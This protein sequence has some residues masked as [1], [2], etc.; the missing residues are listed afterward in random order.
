MDRFATPAACRR[1]LAR[2][3]GALALLT[4]ALAGPVAA[5]APAAGGGA[6]APAPAA[7]PAASP[8]AGAVA[9]G[10]PTIQQLEAMASTLENP[11]ARTK[12]VEQLRAL[13][14]A[15]K[16]LTPAKPPEPEASLPQTLGASALSFLAAHIDVLNR[17]LVQVGNI[18]ADLPGAVAWIN[19]QME[20][21]TSRDRWAQIGFELSLILSVGGATAWG[22]W[23][24]LGRP[25][26]A[27]A[28][29]VVPSP[30][31]RIPPLLARGALELVP[32][33]AFI[34]IAYAVLSVTEPGP[35]V[36]LVVLAVVNASVIV[37]ALLIVV[38]MLVAPGAPNLRLIRAGEAGARRA[39]VWIR[40][41]IAAAVYGYFL[42]E[43]AYVMGLPLG[44]Y[45]ALL[46]LLGVL[47]AG[48]LIVLILQN[49]ASVAA[50]MHGNPLS[51]DGDPEATAE[52]EAEGQGAVLQSAR[53]R[54]ADVWHVL[55]IAYVSVTLGVWVLNVYGGFEYLARATA[56]TVVSVAVARLAVT[57]VNRGLR[58]SLTANRDLRGSLPQLYE[59]AFFYLPI[60]QRVGKTLIW[61]V[62]LGV[63]LNGWGV[64]SLAWTESA[65]GRRIVGSALSISLLLSGAVVAW[66][67]VSALIEHFLTS[68]DHDGTRIERSARVRTL[69]PL[70][71]NAF[72]ILLV[73]MVSLITLSELGVNIA[74]LLAGAG[75]V[76]LAIGFGSQSLVKDI[77]T[78]LFILFE[79][80]VSV[81]DSVD[82]GGGHSGTVEAISIRS[83]RLRDGAGA[84]HSVPFSAVTTVKNMSKDFSIALFNVSVSNREDPDRVIAVLK[85][86]GAEI[87]A[88]QRLGFDILTPLEVMGV[89]KLSDTG[90]NI[91]AQ[92]KTKPTRQWG[93]S[94]AFNLRMKKRFDELGI[95][96]PT[97]SMQLVVGQGA[98]DRA[99][100]EALSQGS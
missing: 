27:L 79:D 78:G 64:D 80:T 10:E 96:M 46:K 73:T 2:L 99:M 18:V 49:R 50:W 90:V 42:A 5:A 9:A 31:M 88:D 84:V 36:R 52:R 61:L 17:Q 23:W 68:T 92:F 20:D 63:V 53:R 72:L 32:I 65:L 8:P 56:I 38:G 81:G 76:G 57:G 11:E 87:Q 77:I 21:S 16:G 37:Q 15:Q 45:G 6:V 54:F 85:E 22:I 13:V 89:D 98:H 40:R 47:I 93:V 83:I 60:L 33:I 100:A 59:R 41:L 86:V 51:G 71:R 62:A 28:A 69:L 43:A 48:M 24:L 67:V 35:R 12:L 91:L 19:R 82:V 70:L 1:G 39:Y 66:E 26:R 58:R 55:A 94:R 74:P 97:Q 34:V 95:T 30:L 14:A 25:H 75:V 44:A 7:T 3:F 4:L 29:R